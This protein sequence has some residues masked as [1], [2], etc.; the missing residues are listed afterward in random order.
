[1]CIC[2]SQ[3]NQF[4][5]QLPYD[6]LAIGNHELYI[7]NNTLDMY[8]DFAPHW[9]GRYLSSNAN[10]TFPI[11]DLSSADPSDVK[12]MSVPVGSRYAKFSTP[13]GR[14]VTSLGVLFNFTGNDEGTTV[15]PVEEMVKEQWVRVPSFLSL[16]SDFGH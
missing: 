11:T 4:I 5:K 10:I 7:Y 15:Q 3:S 14:R 8:T 9:N 1:M 12:N 16:I 13:M 6:I 2:Y